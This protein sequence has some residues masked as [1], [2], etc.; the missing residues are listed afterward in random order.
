MAHIGPS[1]E[2]ID[3]EGATAGRAGEPPPPPTLTDDFYDGRS[4]FRAR[5]ISA[6]GACSLT[7]GRGRHPAALSATNRIRVN[8]TITI[9]GGQ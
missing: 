1:F 5:E 3:K 9:G 8:T 2:S 7:A 4:F 6:R